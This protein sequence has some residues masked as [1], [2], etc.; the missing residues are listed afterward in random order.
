MTVKIREL[1][2][3]SGKWYVKIDY[4]QHR[5]ARC[6]SSK[7]RAQEVA[8]KITDALDIY[9][10]EALRMF[11]KPEPPPPASTKPSPTV[12][13][14][15]SR[16]E[17][18]LEKKDLKHS[19]RISYKSNLKHHIVPALGEVLIANV[20]YSLLKEFVCSKAEATYSSARFRKPKKTPRKN[21]MCR[22]GMRQ[23]AKRNTAVIRF[24]SW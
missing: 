23:S 11:K 10:A 3:K 20:D 14:F 22:L 15:A 21:R 12:A 7:D 5:V 17:L 2:P 13:E 8:K 6:F 9:G 16:W 1:P 18:E 4:H 24:E 19:T